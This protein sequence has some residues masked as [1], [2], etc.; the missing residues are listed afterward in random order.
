MHSFFKRKKKYKIFVLIQ[1]HNIISPILVA[2]VKY[3]KQN[4][5]HKIIKPHKLSYI[6]S[7]QNFDNS[8]KP[9][10]CPERTAYMID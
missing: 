8:W 3:S 2:T 4:M 5:P 6:F 9:N 7:D 1:N 10:P